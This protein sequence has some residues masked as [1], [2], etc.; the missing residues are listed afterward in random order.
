MADRELGIYVNDHLTGA[1]SGVALARRAAGNSADEARTRMWQ[2]VAAEVAEDR[3]ILVQI[4]DLIGARPNRLKY[5]TAWIGEKF[6]RLKLNGHLWKKSDLGQLLELELM[7]LGVTG[8]LALWR[9]LARV[10]DPRLREVDFDRL[11]DRAES[12][13]T[14]L[15]QA[16]LEVAATSLGQAE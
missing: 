2:S 6:G 7:V 4:R 12:Q 1:T 10:Q 15:D 11:C 3:E 9:A 16:R 5:A 8:K 13:R 14:R